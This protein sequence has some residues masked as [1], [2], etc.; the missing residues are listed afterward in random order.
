VVIKPKIR[1]FICTTAH[2]IG[3][4]AHVQ[5]QIDY[6]NDHGTVENGPKKVLIIGSSTGYG[7]ASR[8]VAAFGSGAATIGVFFEREA[9]GKR[10]ATAGYYNSVAVEQKAQ[11]RGLY[12]KSFNGDAYSD[13]IKAQVIEAI[14]EDLGGV[15]LVIY[16]LAAPRRQHP[17]TGEVSKSVLKPVGGEYTNKSIN[18]EKDELEE[19][20]LPQAT[21]EEIDQTISVMG[22]E[23]WQYWIDAL[24]AENLLEQGAKTVAYT[25]VGPEITRGVYRNGTIGKAKEHLEATAKIL[26]E[27]LKSID[28]RAYISANKAL[29]TQSSSAIP[30]IP[31]YFILLNKIMKERNMEEDCIAQIH[32]LFKG[33]LYNGCSPQVDESGFI[34]LD[35]LE[36]RKDIQEIVNKHWEMLN[37]G[38]LSELA[39]LT[40]YHVDFLKLFGFGLK[41]VDYESDVDPDVKIPSLSA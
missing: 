16:S 19:V 37:D 28:G 32:R 26:D 23:D 18:M 27:S 14:K 20:T 6:I 21:Q 40:G 30:F 2:P 12:C 36:M 4:A 17:K 7:L 25:Y 11:E 31:L 8:I 22:G 33:Y 24:L 34:R 41:G 10:T 13:E 5:E 9:E 35:D 15:D 1:G 39:D 38:N 3:C 29:V